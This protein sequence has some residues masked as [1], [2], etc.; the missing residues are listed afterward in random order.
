[1]ILCVV[2]FI[3]GDHCM[4]TRQVGRLSAE[5]PPDVDGRDILQLVIASFGLSE[6]SLLINRLRHSSHSTWMSVEKLARKE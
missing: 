1:M 4:L 2:Y 6:A 5:V 3:A